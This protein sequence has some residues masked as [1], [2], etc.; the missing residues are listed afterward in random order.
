MELVL[1]GNIV[2]WQVLVYQVKQLDNWMIG[3]L[4]VLKSHYANI[5]CTGETIC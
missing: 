3:E 1:G 4:V 5:I 2:Q